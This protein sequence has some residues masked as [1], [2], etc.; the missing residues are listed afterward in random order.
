MLHCPVGT[1]HEDLQAEECRLAGRK[2]LPPRGPPAPAW[3]AVGHLRLTASAPAQGFHRLL[4]PGL[5]CRREVPRPFALKVHPCET[6]ASVA[7]GRE[8]ATTPLPDARSC[9]PPFRIPVSVPTHTWFQRVPAAAIAEPG[10]RQPHFR[11]SVC[12]TSASRIGFGP[13]TFLGV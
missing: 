5:S 12:V 11:R 2:R 3:P 6:R 7:P 1:A 8:L 10:S 9:H 4:A 13:K